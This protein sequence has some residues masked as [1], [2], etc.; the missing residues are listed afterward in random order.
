MDGKLIVLAG[1][2]SSRMKDSLNSGADINS[3]LISDAR[4]KS[5]SMI[6]VGLNKRP[7]LDYVLLNARSA[8]YKDVV[9]LINEKDQ[10]IK[11]YYS[12]NPF[13][14]LNIFYA[15]QRIPPDRT[16]PLGTADALYQAVIAKPE[17]KGC[18]FT[19]CNSDNLY[20]VNAFKTL[21]GTN[22]KNAMIDY[23]I[24]GFE[25]DKD[26]IGKFAVT[27]KDD[28]GYLTDIIEKLNSQEIQIIK[29][30]N[31][32]VGVSMNIFR[33]SYDMIIPYLEKVE[34]NPVRNE[35]ELPAAIKLM[36]NENPKSLYAYPMSEHVPDLT[37]KNDIL[38]I[39]KIL[40]NIF[41]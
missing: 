35:K 16:K 21:L 7:F 18:A 41:Q 14:G 12:K 10:S 13:Q 27:F 23:N 3:D 39:Q 5:K 29:E 8:G 30:K 36:I 32:Y 19:V 25:Y 40:K 4:S 38:V 34:I 20:S 6:G 31:G 28:D 2:V 24:D 9:I 26:R 22:H 15:V 11:E 37:S 33:L 1:G 17:W